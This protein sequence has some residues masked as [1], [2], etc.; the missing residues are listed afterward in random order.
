MKKLGSLMVIMVL[1][2]WGCVTVD[3]STMVDADSQGY[4]TGQYRDV[5]HGKV[6]D[7]GIYGGGAGACAAASAAGA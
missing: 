4:A 2:V 1:G 7:F 5:R 3:N 6:A